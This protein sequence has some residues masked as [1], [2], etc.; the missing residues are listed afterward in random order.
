[1]SSSYQSEAYILSRDPGDRTIFIQTR[2]TL[3]RISPMVMF[4]LQG[5]VTKS[6]SLIGDYGDRTVKC[7]INVTHF[8]LSQIYFLYKSNNTEQN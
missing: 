4:Y 8:V 7:N 3:G 2:E 5:H 6:S 1:M